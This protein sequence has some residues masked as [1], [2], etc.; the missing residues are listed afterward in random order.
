M[1]SQEDY[2][3][4]LLKDMAKDGETG[5]AE[6]SGDFEDLDLE[7]LDLGEADLGEDLMEAEDSGLPEDLSESSGKL[8]D[9]QAES[10]VD[11]DWDETDVSDILGELDGEEG[12]GDMSGSLDL[13]SVSEMTEE[14]IE[15]LLRLPRPCGPGPLQRRP[16]A[17]VEHLIQVGAHA[18][19]GI[20]RH[21]LQ[22]A[23]SGCV[24]APRGNFLH[25]HLGPPGPQPLHRPVLGSGVQHH[26]L[27]CF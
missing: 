10:A 2:L 23:V 15:K 17:R 18:D 9:I 14:E 13:D 19:T 5:E 1:P 26:H 20:L 21:Q 8:A 16:P 6:F 11:G 12:I 4:S 3:D 25:R 22:R 7:S 24:K 27:V